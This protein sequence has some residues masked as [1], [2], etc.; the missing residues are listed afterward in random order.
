MCSRESDERRGYTDMAILLPEGQ[1][2]T[3]S[4]VYLGDNTLKHLNFCS[5]TLFCVVRMYKEVLRVVMRWK[6]EV[7]QTEVQKIT[8]LWPAL[9]APLPKRVWAGEASIERNSQE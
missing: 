5:K 9:F 8:H 2:G 3:Q 7:Y 6:F 1:N 4:I